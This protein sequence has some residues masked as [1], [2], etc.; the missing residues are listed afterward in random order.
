VATGKEQKFQGIFSPLDIATTK[1]KRKKIQAF[2]VS[3]VQEKM[4]QN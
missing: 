2:L 4:Q 3:H 1:Q